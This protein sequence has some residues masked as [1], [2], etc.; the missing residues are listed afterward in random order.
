[1]SSIKEVLDEDLYATEQAREIFRRNVNNIGQNIDNGQIKGETLN[2]L[3][4]SVNASARRAN[5]SDAKELLRDLEDA[6]IETL[7]QGDDEAIMQAKQQY[8]NLLVI[9][10]LAAKSQGGN[11]SPSQLASR[12]NRIYGRSYVRGKAGEIG[13]LAR[14]GSEL[15]PQLGGS[16]TQARQMMERIAG[17][18]T[19]GLATVGSATAV[20]VP[21]TAALL[22]GNRAGQSFLNRNQAIIKLMTEPQRKALF[23][24]PIDKAQKYLDGLRQG[25]TLTPQQMQEEQ[26]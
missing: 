7:S 4:S 1:M 6:I 8:K 15:L 13:D 3:R 21:G 20:G 14:I 16:D 24:M 26:E 23:K 19:G 18:L 25:I 2:K 17:N 11:I 5:D 9:E 12:V 22:A 10:P